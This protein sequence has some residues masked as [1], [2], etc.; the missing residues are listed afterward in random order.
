MEISSEFPLLLVCVNQSLMLLSCCFVVSFPLRQLHLC[1]GLSPRI[2]I[3]LIGNISEFYLPNSSHT[4]S[5]KP[6]FISAENL[7]ISWHFITVKTL[8]EKSPDFSVVV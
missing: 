5:I 1:K 7:I 6:M 8:I 3:C 4:D 2:N